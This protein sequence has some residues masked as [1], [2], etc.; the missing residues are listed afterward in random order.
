[1][2]VET[3]AVSLAGQALGAAFDFLGAKSARA[4]QE[5]AF[6]I[7]EEQAHDQLRHNYL[8]Q[9]IR[10]VT[11]RDRA[12]ARIQR[13]QQD[14]DEA[15]AIATAR[16]AE[17][18]VGGQSA[19]E[20]IQEFERDR[21]N[22]IAA[23]LH[24]ADLTDTNIQLAKQGANLRTEAGILSS[25]PTPVQGPDLLSAAFSIGAGAYDLFFGADDTRDR[26]TQINEG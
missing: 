15:I 11:E 9:S 25:V 10:Q 3:A 12:N 8:S 7:R 16:Q 22:A 14:G 18:G 4:E 20:V 24:N 19:L 5:A 13:I 23:E 17:S 1:M 6:R 2:C 21:S 26:V